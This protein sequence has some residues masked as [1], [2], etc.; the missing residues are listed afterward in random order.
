MKEFI[1]KYGEQLK[2][3]LSGWDRLVIRGT[4]R[5]LSFV[6][7]MEQYLRGEKVLLKD[8]G[9]YVAEVSERVKAASLAEARRWGRPIQYLASS[10]VSK[11]EVARQW[12]KEFVE[13]EGLLGVITAVEPCV[14][15]EV[16]R[17][18][19][20][21][22]LELVRRHRK[23]LFLYHYWRHPVLGFMQ[24]R[25]QSWFPF[26]IQ[27]CLN[28][29][30][31]LARQMQEARIDYVQADNCFPWVADFERAQRLVGEQSRVNWK[32]VL[33]AIRKAL[34][35]LHEDL[36]RRFRVNYYWS[37]Y[38]SEWATDLVFREAA[39]LREIYPRLL[40]YS[41]STFGSAEVL[42][43]LGRPVTLQGEVRADFHGNVESD[44]RRRPEGVRIKHRANGNSV[45]AYDKAFTGVGSVM[46]VETTINQAREFRVYRAKEG[47]PHGPKDWRVLRRGVADLHRRAVVSQ[48]VNERYLQG[49]ANLENEV[50]LEQ[51][52]A[53]MERP[54][55]WNHQRVRALHPFEAED[56]RLLDA[57]SRTEFALHGFRNRDLQALLFATPT[58]DPAMRR[59][60]SAQVSRKIRLL[61][62]HGLIR[63]IPGQHRYHLTQFGGKAVTAVLAAGQCKV[64]ELAKAV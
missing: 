23:C 58:T 25:L 11:E 27:V 51:Y 49:W 2:G 53:R 22:R 30:E 28:G 17:N 20:Q 13:G 36:F 12:E 10:R 63:K 18:R 7:G 37:V 34:H 60:R 50:R 44:L 59:R 6:E 41:M 26:A 39:V 5:G 45:K 31:W 14:S 32:M 4:L 33:E 24:A 16:Y 62:A 64:S 29:R 1:A 52:T 19:E 15:Y 46:R 61:R 56:G 9:R 40:R 54:V 55:S 47:D 48:Q 8:F 3:V 43:F 21:G 35:P 38:Q 42:R 57:V